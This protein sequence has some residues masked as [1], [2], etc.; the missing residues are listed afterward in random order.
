MPSTVVLRRRTLAVQPLLITAAR[1]VRHRGLR[2]RPELV[3]T[4]RQQLP[5]TLRWPTLQPPRRH[6]LTSDDDQQY[7]PSD[8][9]MSRKSRD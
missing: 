8:F 6:E 7:E 5:R 1:P 2:P 4:W 9:W 3:A